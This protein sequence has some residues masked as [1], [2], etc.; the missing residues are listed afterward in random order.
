MAPPT[1]SSIS[2]PSGPT[3]GGTP[4]TLQGTHFSGL[5][6][7]DLAVAFGSVAAECVSVVSAEELVAVAPPTGAVGS[8]GVTVSTN[9]GATSPVQY[10]YS[11]N[12]DLVTMMALAQLA[13][14]ASAER[15][16]GDTRERQQRR[17]LDGINAQLAA[18]TS[19]LS[20]SWEAVWV[21]LTRDRANLAYIAHN[22]SIDS[23]LQYALSL[24]GTQG[25]G[26]DILEDLEVATM[27][28]FIGGNVSAGA[29][30][31]FTEVV[32]G[33]GLL[34]QLAELL[35]GQA[36]PPALYVS[37]HSLG[38][39]MAT[40]LA[41]YL[42]QQSWSPAPSIGVYTFAAPT[43]G[44]GGFASAFSAA[45]PDAACVWNQYDIVPSAWWNLVDTGGGGARKPPLLE[46]AEHFWPGMDPKV[47]LET[48]QLVKRIAG[49][50]KG[51]VYV[52]PNSLQR[53][54]LVLNACYTHTNPEVTKIA[55]LGDWLKELDYQHNSYLELLGGPSVPD[56]VPELTSIS[57]TA[58]GGGCAVTIIGD[59]F[60]PD[61]VV[62]FGIVPAEVVEVTP[63]ALTAVAPPG[64]GTVDVRVT[65]KYGTSA[66]GA[67]D[68]F[69]Y[70]S[71]Q[72]S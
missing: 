39:A 58:G 55:S 37:G 24:R 18:I 4:V 12:L 54:P 31:A 2:P 34:A 59:N 33:T 6:V 57:P 17:I 38:G 61:S 64:A 29:M 63:T 9:H 43:A 41:L 67:Q 3:C 66:K 56:L 51:N 16:S 28:P 65:T 26:I 45:F 7:R 69:T 72:A 11:S 68:R 71:F 27:L 52:Q 25:F 47:G 14:T 19:Q 10:S 21:G 35:N 50:A 48:S 15:P 44:D 62:D 32:M 36:A 40:T 30:E 60:T 53:P 46:A 8:V 1:L 20:G 22:T 49:A 70:D 23:P 42:A 13:G 5:D